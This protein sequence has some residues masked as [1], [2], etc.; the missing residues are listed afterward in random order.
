[1]VKWVTQTKRKKRGSKF[2]NKIILLSSLALLPAF[3]TSFAEENDLTETYHVY[4]DDKHIGEVDDKNIVQQVIND[5]VLEKLNKY[6]DVR[7][8]VGQSISMIPEKAFKL[9]YNNEY[10]REYLE[11][12]LT[13]NALAAEINIDHQTVGYFR[14]EEEAEKVLKEYKLKYISEADLDRLENIDT[15]DDTIEEEKLSVGDSIVSDIEFSKDVSIVEKEVSIQD[16]LSMEQGVNLLEKGT[17][18]EKVHKVDNGEVLG[19][20]AKKYDL[21]IK[22]LLELNPSLTED[23]ILQIDQEINV[24]EYQPF[25][26]VLVYEDKLV[27]EKV[28]YSTEIIESEDMYK[29]EEKVKQK[30]K[31]GKKEVQYRVENSNGKEVKKSVIDEKVIKEPVDKVIVKGTKVIPSRGSG[32]LTWPANGGYVS[33]HLGKRWGTMHKGIDIA[34]PTTRDIY[35][36]DHGVVESA[37]WNSGGYGNKIVI[38]HNNGMRTV[39]AH[40]SDIDVESGQVV[41][42]GT[43]IGTMGSTGKSTGVHLHFEVYQD[44]TLMNPMDYY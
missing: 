30:G 7:I 24:T 2:I 23:A 31:S 29:G 15:T 33:S 3:M 36:A 18:E 1:M 11:E 4:V 26:N 5:K 38:N 16:I 35:A 44:G 14:N 39:Y 12:H 8:I 28:D 43:K 42:K 41:E 13:I 32:D 19:Q 34:R 9:Q 22:K 21:T 40:L 6:E 20:I 27:E 10:V 37:G 25:V 17:L